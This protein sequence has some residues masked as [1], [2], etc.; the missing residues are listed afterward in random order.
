MCYGSVEVLDYSQSEIVTIEDGNGKIQIGT[1]RILHV[2]NLTEYATII[3]EL[4][5]EF[6]KNIPS[7]H[8]LHP[9]IME[10]INNTIINIH[11]IIPNSRGK[12]SL[13]FI[14]SAWKWVAGNPDHDDL[15]A[16]NNKFEEVI[17]NNNQ[18]LIINK[19]ILQRI[20]NITKVSNSI[21]KILK[22]SSEMQ[23]VLILQYKFKI[24]IIKEE[25]ENINK[26]IHLTKA[27]IINTLI[28]SKQEAGKINE[29][30]AEENMPFDSL[31]ESLN[32]AEVKIAFKENILIYIVKVPKTGTDICNSFII[33]PL[34]KNNTILKIKFEKILKCNEKYYGME[35]DCKSINDIKI[36]K[37]D[38]IIDL[39]KEHCIRNLLENKPYDC[40]VTNT[41]HI[42]NIEEISNGLILLNG[43]KGNIFIK[44][45]EKKINGT[46]LIKIVNDT[47]RIN[48]L[49]FTAV[50]TLSLRPLPALIKHSDSRSE[51]EEI[52]SLKFMKELNIKNIKKIDSL[53]LLTKSSMFAHFGLLASIMILILIFKCKKRRSKEIIIKNSEHPQRPP[54]IPSKRISL[55]DI[56]YF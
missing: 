26:A 38:E 49:S 54:K 43:F 28:L 3:E 11:N 41:E 20:N 8:P 5:T 53:N 55:N 9:F 7:S 25:I 2:I 45:Y 36:C 24:D 56:P 4:R 40:I 37:Q 15:V 21:I 39:E 47:V 14:G 23:T 35:T 19:D 50:E 52:L 33:K 16:I 12:R 1:Y 29:I 18:Q 10:E 42:K 51:F 44:N 48:D 34:S 6:D 17:E 22:G 13:N 46:Y 30:F 27:N 31:E 32:F